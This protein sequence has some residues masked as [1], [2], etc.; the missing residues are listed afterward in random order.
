MVAAASVDRSTRG[1]RGRHWALDLGR[2]FVEDVADARQYTLMP[3]CAT[4]GERRAHAVRA[5]AT[6]AHGPYLAA[7]VID[8]L[9]RKSNRGVAPA[10]DSPAVAGAYDSSS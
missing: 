3:P 9:P 2:D 1:T 6:I 4:R 7:N 10:R 5:P 8:L